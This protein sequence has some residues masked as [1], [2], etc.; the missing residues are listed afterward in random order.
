MK[1]IAFLHI[2]IGGTYSIIEALVIYWLPLWEMD[3][4]TQVQTLDEAVCI[5][6]NSNIL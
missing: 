4:A 1:K 6:Y 2:K 5:S 3:T